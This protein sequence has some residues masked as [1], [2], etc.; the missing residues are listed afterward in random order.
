MTIEQIIV[1]FE[2]Q[3]IITVADNGSCVSYKEKE[4]E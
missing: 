3:G 2:T 4:N 1:L